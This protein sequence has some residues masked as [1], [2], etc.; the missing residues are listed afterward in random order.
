LSKTFAIQEDKKE[1]DKRGRRVKEMM[2][3]TEVG[4]DGS[5]YKQV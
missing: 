4:D 3:E 1:E 5:E 2:R